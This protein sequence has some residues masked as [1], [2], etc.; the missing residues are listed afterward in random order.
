ME[1][2]Q[3]LAKAKGTPP[4]SQLFKEV[5]YRIYKILKA[6]YLDEFYQKVLQIPTQIYKKNA[7]S[8]G[9]RF[10]SC[11]PDIDFVMQGG[12]IKPSFSQSPQMS[13]AS[14][15]TELSANNQS[16]NN[17]NSSGSLW[18]FSLFSRKSQTKT[19]SG[20]QPQT[21]KSLPVTIQKI[22]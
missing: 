7:C 16:L 13:T 12:S 19:K 3:Q 4:D 21:D 20:Q 17:S 2:N 9:L 1:K 11:G 10:N 22:G 5:H 14:N 8:E 6:N 15:V 18:R